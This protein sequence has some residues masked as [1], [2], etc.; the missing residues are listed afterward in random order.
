MESHKRRIK[1]RKSSA[2]PSFLFGEAPKPRGVLRMSPAGLLCLWDHDLSPLQGNQRDS[3][4][5][6]PG[7]D[8]A[9][10]PDVPGGAAGN[11]G[12]ICVSEAVLR[13]GRS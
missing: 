3:H 7:R 1:Q 4:S 2:I 10:E 5:Q 8:L 11:E 13:R 9:T 12:G 6:T